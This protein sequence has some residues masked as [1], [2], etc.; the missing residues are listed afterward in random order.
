MNGAMKW[1]TLGAA[2]AGMA[3]GPWC[4][5]GAAQ[6]NAG[7]GPVLVVHSAGLDALMPDERDAKLR[8]ALSMMGPR[9][10]RLQQDFEY[11]PEAPDVPP[12]LPELAWNI[13]IS[14]MSLTFD[15]VEGDGAPPQPS[16][17]LIA[18]GAGGP[19]SARALNAMA[20]RFMG[21]MTGGGELPPVGDQGL[22]TISMP[23][24]A[25]HF[26]VSQVA[27]AERF[28]ISFGGFDGREPEHVRAGLERG[29]DIIVAEA[30][31]G[32]EGDVVLEM[33]ETFGVA[34]P[35][36]IV[37]ETSIGFS[38]D[39]MHSAF[40]MGNAASLC[41]RMGVPADSSFSPETLGILPRDAISA[42]GGL[43]SVDWILPMIDRLRERDPGVPDVRAEIREQFG[44]DIKTELL[45][46]IGLEW[47]FHRA[48]STGGGLTSVVFTMELDDQRTFADTH[49]RIVEMANSMLADMAEGWARISTWR[50]SGGETCF[51]LVAPGL[52]VPV[53]PVWGIKDGRLVVAAS[54]QAL[55]EAFA[56]IGGRGDSLAGVPAI[57][58]M[59]ERDPASFI[60]FG[61]ADTQWLARKG[62]PT[63]M[64]ATTAL[65]SMVRD[66]QDPGVD[67]GVILPPVQALM[68]GAGPATS[69]WRRTGGDI[70]MLTEAGSSWLANLSVSLGASAGFGGLFVPTVMAGTLLPALG[71]A[72]EN[73][74]QIEA[75]AQVRAIAQ[76]VIEFRA[77]TGRMPDSLGELADELYLTPELLESPAGP[78]FD[79]G[80]DFVALLDRDWGSAP[81]MI[82]LV[83]RAAYYN[84]QTHAA[85]AYGDGYVEHIPVWDLRN[86]LEE[87]GTF[88]QF[89]LQ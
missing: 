33:L 2:G 29:I 14:P 52:P 9:L 51:S 89:G 22:R 1:L 36:A 49:A 43:A 24:G 57:R 78:A 86:I 26:G 41:A 39:R 76:A 87:Q 63:A 45:D 88:E 23:Q 68:A 46:P 28:V 12:V 25:M 64:L 16:F 35:D 19:T 13:L 50:T 20:E 59:A 37:F 4:A 72:R 3:I 61:Y 84:G 18:G 34:G 30:P 44:I 42:M 48:A 38:A 11:L 7:D 65:E 31:R 53:V 32:P 82:V 66:R 79:G 73:A 58:E 17:E 81:E 70:V 55:D 27:G 80:P 8:T 47:T 74:Q 60:G 5:S 75:E 67:P 62:Y 56:L 77:E 6:P 21:M 69:D 83:D 10:A 40:R 85:I 71:A 15:I 54:K